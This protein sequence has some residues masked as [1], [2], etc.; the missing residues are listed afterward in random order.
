MSKG[1]IKVHSKVREWTGLVRNAIN[2]LLVFEPIKQV[3]LKKL[4]KQGI[5]FCDGYKQVR[6]DMILVEK[7]NVKNDFI[8]V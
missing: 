2:I 3:K 8:D 4:C 5:L 6:I 1:K 7:S